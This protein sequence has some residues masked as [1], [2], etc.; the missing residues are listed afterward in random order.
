M[1]RLTEIFTSLADVST[2]SELLGFDFVQNALIAVALLGLV[3]GLIGPFVVMRNM[4]FSVHGT[5]E[6]ALTGA[7][8]HRGS[9]SPGERQGR[10]CAFSAS[11]R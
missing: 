8:A 1:E 5:S 11:L 4:G 3:A 2:T 9:A 7:A 10:G 6:L